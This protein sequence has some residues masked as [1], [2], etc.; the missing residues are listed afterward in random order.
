MNNIN[1]MMEQGQQGTYNS[2]PSIYL[3]P[4]FA[5]VTQKISKSDVQM[6]L[7]VI[8]EAMSQEHGLLESSSEAV[9]KYIKSNVLALNFLNKRNLK[10][11]FQ[12]IQNNLQEYI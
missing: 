10:D 2:H 5:D 7:Q 8:L 1:L 4:A 3:N 12:T 11:F 6:M 9:S